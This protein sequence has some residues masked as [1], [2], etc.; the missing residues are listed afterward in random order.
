MEAKKPMAEPKLN[1]PA[2]KAAAAKAK[3]LPAA[4]AAAAVPP[5]AHGDKN[6][7][8]A[9][10]AKSAAKTLSKAAAGA[11]AKAKAPAKAAAAKC[12][13]SKATAAKAEA[14]PPWGKNMTR[15]CV[16]S[17][18]YKA[19]A[20]AA[21]DEGLDALQISKAA[22]AAGKKAALDW[23]IEFGSGSNSD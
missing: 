15:K 4:K 7:F 19:A 9:P 21:K 22:C 11:K 10:T 12:A 5:T 6:V 1:L 13:A 18:A 3:G 8:V 20:K 2:A 14:K 17:R 23:D 16:H